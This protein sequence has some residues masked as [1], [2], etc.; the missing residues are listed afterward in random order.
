MSDAGAG[1]RRE[2]FV[3]TRERLLDGRHL[4][5]LRARAT[6]DFTV[7][8]DE[9]LAAS[10]EAALAEH[11]PGEDAWV[12]GY[13]SLM[14]NPAFLHEEH[15]LGTVRGWHRSF[16]LR[17]TRGRGTPDCPGLMLALDRGG[18][19]RGMGFRIAAER[20]REELLLVWRR[21]MLSGAYLA[22]WV[23]VETEAG[24]VRAVTFV[25]NRAH[26]RY[27]GRLADEATA[28]RI[29]IAAGEL[30]TCRDYF[31]RTVTALDAFGIRDAALS[32]IG[33]LL[34]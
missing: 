23:Q 10:L 13:G 32:R 12:F 29:R 15:R 27:L 1:K 4:D 8:S 21:E 2:P 30:G 18:L 16:C 5:A 22:R 6:P 26:P 14:W 3:I 24:R 17:M 20:V 19:C 7:R 31:D 11:R 33:R 28:E 34:A 25:A 9:E